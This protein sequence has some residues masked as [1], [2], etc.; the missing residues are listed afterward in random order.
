MV[1]IR[2]VHGKGRGV[3]AGRGFAKGELVERAPVIVLPDPQWEYLEKTALKDYYYT[4]GEDAIAI[5]V[6][7]GMLYNHSDAPNVI[8]VRNFEE[9]LV[10]L[11]ALCDIKA[12][13]EITHRYGCPPWFEVLP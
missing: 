12:G 9:Q 4:W 2:E 8:V 3:F 6:G 11:I 10:E 13:E 1:Y 7:F 5:V